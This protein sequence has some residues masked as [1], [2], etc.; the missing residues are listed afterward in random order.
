[1]FELII[2]FVIAAVSILSA[3]GVIFNKNVVHSALTLLLHFGS[4][5]FLYFMLNAQFLG[6]AQI[7]VYAGAIVVLFLFVVML[8]G[9]DLGEQVGSWASGQ[10]VFL[11]ALGLILLTVIGAALFGN[12]FTGAKGEMT[13]AA[14]A[15]A[16]Q[17]Q[18]IAATLFT[19]YTLPFKLVAVLLTVGVIGVVWLAHHQQRQK[20]RQVVAVL[21]AA[22]PGETQQVHQDKLRV[23][24]LRRPNLFDFDWVE[25]KQATDAEVTRFAGQISQDTDN[26]RGLRYPQMVCVVAPEVRLSEDTLRQTWENCFGE[27]RVAEVEEW[28]HDWSNS[29]I[30]LP[31]IERRP[32]FRLGRRWVLIPAQYPD[33]FNVRGN[34][35]E[36]GQPDFQR[37]FQLPGFC[38]R[39]VFVFMEMAVAAVEVAVGLAQLVELTR[40]KDAVEHQRVQ[41]IEGIGGR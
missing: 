39:A 37:L 28:E 32:L 2:F 27:V 24:W 25:I 12:A 38:H 22:W 40:H 6:V 13:P 7:L 10:N 20:Y 1:M 4:L 33:Y 14:I 16:G 11:M 5:A 8:I 19:E 29:A 26:W 17:V 23:N 18:I 35:D 31:V 21:D 15:Q 3:L 36:R 41:F 34:D 9:A 30:V